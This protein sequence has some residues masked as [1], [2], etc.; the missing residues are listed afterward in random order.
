MPEWKMHNLENDRK[1]PSW[2]MIE[3]SQMFTKENVRK[4]TTWKKVT[5]AVLEMHYLQIAQPEN[6]GIENA[7]NGK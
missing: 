3:K 1:V 2:N 4:I 6:A 5:K 7:H